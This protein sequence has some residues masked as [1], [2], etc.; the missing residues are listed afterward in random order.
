MTLNEPISATALDQ[1]F[2]KAR[3]ANTFTADPVPDADIHRLYDLVKAGPSAYNCQP[4]R[5]I[6]LRP[7]SGRDRL[8]P[9]VSEGNQSK[10]STAPITIIAAADADFHENIP[11]VFPHAPHVKD[12]F[13]G[14]DERFATAS[15]NASIQLGGLI[16]AVRSLG[17]AAGPITGFDKAAVTEEFFPGRNVATL[18]L[19]NMGLPGPDAWDE[20]LPRL[21]FDQA[22]EII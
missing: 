21:R 2:R 9:F 11:Q 15:L 7:G 1:V 6:F 16:M 17:Y 10:V 20:K 13:G 3:T 12:I 18:A 22:A 4:L 5:L 19:V 14:L 8:L